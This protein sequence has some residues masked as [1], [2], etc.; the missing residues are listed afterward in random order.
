MRRFEFVE[1][2]SKKFW[3]IALNGAEFEVRWGRIGTSGQSQTKSFA[4]DAKA[5]A[6]HDKLVKEKTGKGYVE[7]GAETPT[8]PATAA[9]P[10]KSPVA[11]PKTA[12]PKEVA[13]PPVEIAPAPKLAPAAEPAPAPDVAWNDTF[14]ATDP[15]TWPAAARAELHPFRAFPLEPLSIDKQ[16]LWRSLKARFAENASATASNEALSARM[17]QETFPT[18][19][20]SPELEAR[21]A[22][23]V[24]LKDPAW[25]HVKWVIEGFVLVVDMWVLTG[26]C[27]HAVR[28]LRALVDAKHQGVVYAFP[29]IVTRLAHHLALADDAAYAAAEAA[30]ELHALPVHTHENQMRSALIFL[31]AERGLA[32]VDVMATATSWTPGSYAN[33]PPLVVASITTLAALE[34]GTKFISGYTLKTA[35][36]GWRSASAEPT[37]FSFVA[38]FG[39]P[40]LGAFELFLDRS[41][42][43]SDTLRA[44]G[45][46]IALVGTPRA[47]ELLAKHAHVR[48]MLSALR[49]RA[50]ERPLVALR[51]LVHQS[52]QRGAASS[53]CRTILSQLLRTSTPKL[54]GAIEGLA[55]AG[56][57]LIA[58]L[59]AKAGVGLEEASTS[60]LPSFVVTPLW[61]GKKQRVSANVE[62][63]TQLPFV[64]TMGWPQG[65]QA[66]W[67][68]DTTDTWS[69]KSATMPEHFQQRWNIP[70]ELA[71]RLGE[72]DNAEDVEALQALVKANRYF[73]GYA[74][75]LPHYGAR[76]AKKLLHAFAAERW[77]RPNEPLHLLAARHELEFLDAFLAFASAHL[78]EGLDVLLP[79]ASPRVA[80]LAADAQYRLKKKPPAAK[81][82]LL[83]HPEAAAIGLIPKAIGKAGK[84]RDVAEFGLRL[85][86]REG[87]ESTVMEVAARYGDAPKA[88]VRAVLDFDPLQVFPSKMPSLP[89]F[90]KADALPRLV[91]RETGHA[92]PVS[93]MQ[94]V[95]TMLAFSKAGEPYAGITILK[96]LTTVSSQGD[97][98]WELFQS[99]QVAGAD[100]KQGWAFTAMGFF[101]DDECARKLTP[102]LR[103]WPGEAQHQRAVAGLEV[104]AAIGTDVALMHLHGIAQKLKFK[105]L[106]EK[107]REKIDQIADARGLTADELADRLVPD[108]GL[109]E[110]GSLTLDFGS[111]NFR[112]VFDES[113]KP[114]VKEA[115]GKRLGDLPKPRKEDDEAKSKEA[116]ETWKALKKDAKTIAQQQVIRLE[117]AM[118]GRRR[119]SEDVFRPFLVEHPLVR[120]LAQRIV[121]GLYNTEGKLTET[122]RVAEDG[123][124]ANASD[125]VFTLPEGASI[126]VAHTLEMKNEDEAKFG[127]SFADYELLQPFKQLGRETYALTAEEATLPSVARWNGKKI[128][129]GKVLGLEARGWRRG[130]PQ[131]GGHIGWMEKQVGEEVLTV[132]LDPGIAVGMIDEF[133]EQQIYGLGLGD[134]WRWRKQSQK[135]LGDLDVIVISEALRDVE[136]MLG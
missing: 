22:A 26:G 10:M 129:T 136:L 76:L 18:T 123:S 69:A 24:A 128:P 53:P 108:L 28:S 3:E 111:R 30:A 51:P 65:L 95:L 104:L 72:N 60:E 118:C 31:F 115:S 45:S 74:T 112:V 7:V 57:K 122:F 88:A 61:L 48:A 11:K 81:A 109:D 33:V 77:W 34:A 87:H 50:L 131:D 97:F 46:A 84:E 85:L 86:A 41:E 107:A 100:S 5:L 126:G 14:V 98:A 59:R 36:T 2:A 127:Q 133:P 70:A 103:A 62:G 13:N 91:L 27:A 71:Q 92:L 19:T 54:D 99:W 43:D 101:G 6:E 121:W 17:A 1:G 113:L 78:D 90:A 56:K 82:W 83:R 42:M 93:A 120:H 132:E 94:H 64:E 49:D 135:M 68:K 25:T 40:V 9:T 63:L 110:D 89:D 73:Y 102:L 16:V 105:G 79:Y 130:T 66:R 47:F 29:A 23:R 116:T 67:L 134:D 35:E 39:E 44:L 15:R 119:W 55:D 32:D 124:Y 125:D 117:L 114:F 37:L 21:V 12:A 106:Q 8:A 20:L 96:E 75:L 80:M 38:R 58:E 4:S 52:L